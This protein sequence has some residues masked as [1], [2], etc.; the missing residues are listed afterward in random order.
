MQ[1]IGE[2]ESGRFEG[3]G[4]VSGTG[5]PIRLLSARNSTSPTSCILGKWAGHA[6]DA[7]FRL[8]M[9]IDN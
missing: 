1:E 2:D 7:A 5:G 6:A 3:N 8:T 4:R 9:I